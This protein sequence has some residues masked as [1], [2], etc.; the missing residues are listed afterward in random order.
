MDGCGEDSGDRK[1]TTL[2]SLILQRNASF[3]KNTQ[4]YDARGRGTRA[5]RTIWSPM[6]KELPAAA[7]KIRDARQARGLSVAD[8]AKRAGVDPVTLYR[9]ESGECNPRAATTSKLIKALAKIP[10]LP[11]I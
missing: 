4:L 6:A 7:K 10:K 11:E 5:R 8:L 2:H 1:G 9:V 3:R